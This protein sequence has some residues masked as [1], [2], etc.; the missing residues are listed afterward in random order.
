VSDNKVD[1]L[2]L[3][4]LGGVGEIG[5]NMWVVGYGDDLV[6]LD[7]GG[8]FPEEDMLGVD[9]VI[10]D[11]SYLIENS[12][13]VRA[14]VLS[15]GHE[16]HVGALPYVLQQLDVP[17]YGTRLTLGLVQGR[18]EEH[19]LSRQCRLHEVQ[20]GQSLQLGSMTLEFIHVNHSVADVVATAVH[21]PAGTIVYATDFKFDHT[22]IDG[23][24]TDMQRL[25]TLGTNGVLCLLSDSTN[26]ERPGYTLS[27]KVVGETFMDVFRRAQGRILVAAFASH[28]HRIQ[29]VIAASVRF[30]R[31][32]CV[33]G[34][35]MVNNVGVASRLGYLDLPDGLLINV[36]QMEDY[37][38][39][40]LTIITTGSQGEPMAALT[41][42]AMGEHRQIEVVPGDTVIIS[43]SPIPGNERFIGRTINQLFRQG[44]EVIYHAVSG[45][46]VSG[47]AS[48][49]E[50]KL[51]LNLI[52][53][54][55]FIP[56]HGEYRMLVQHA[57][58]AEDVGL[59]PENVMIA[60]IG[61][62][63]EIAATKFE[64]VAKVEAGS[65]MVDG[66]GVGDVGAV[67]L[68]DRQQLAQDGI[69][70]VVVTIDKE[71]GEI[72]AGP[73][74][75][76]RGF[77]YVR[78]SERLFEEAKQRVQ[79]ALESCEPSF[80]EWNVLKNQVRNTLS[81]FFWERTRRRP[82]ILPVVMEA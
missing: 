1:S 75:V 12:D 19:G 72:L 56:I 29:Q 16:D 54:R 4:P 52:S 13:R 25:A 63:I 15:H 31:K 76:S 80:E 11:I 65:I 82:M 51:M 3:V 45:V 27:E 59:S 57:R 9:L 48:Q 64:K 46:H 73:E 62:M 6:V 32:V 70:V 10:P 28:V 60:E 33:I 67:V 53:P 20:A 55:Y 79:V 49:E 47:H 8:M 50:L 30:D 37:P 41:R 7:C 26:A 61:D 58:L 81:G 74:F 34:R 40:K 35:S 69:L 44:A 22:P 23:R 24:V 17:V 14:I 78:E 71:T 43:A 39:E 5:K 38:P 36:E 66:L 68:R 21:T 77:V 18:L 2:I 42:I